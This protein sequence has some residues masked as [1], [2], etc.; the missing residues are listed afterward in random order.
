MV[1]KLLMPFLDQS[2]SFTL[3]FEAG[4]IWTNM[5]KNYSFDKYLVHRENKEQIEMMCKRFLYEFYFEQVDETWMNLTAKLK[6]QIKN[7]K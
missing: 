1:N 2:K 4:Q 3:G 7:K 6:P 5:Q